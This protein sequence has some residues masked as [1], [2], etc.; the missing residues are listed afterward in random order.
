M[1]FNEVLACVL[2][3]SE[4]AAKRARLCR[5]RLLYLGTGAR[6][7]AIEARCLEYELSSLA[8]KIS[9]RLAV[10]PRGN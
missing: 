2:T 5:V 3:D 7:Y 10:M 6:R 8:E 1:S 4:Y 9:K